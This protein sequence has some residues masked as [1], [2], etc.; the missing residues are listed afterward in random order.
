MTSQSARKDVVL[1]VDD[2]PESLGMIN[3][4]LDAAGLTV[5]VALEGQQALTIASNITPDIILLD[6]LMPNMD[7]FETCR[8]L[9]ANR[10]LGHIPVIFMTGLSDTES[11]V[12]GLEAGGVDYIQKPVNGDELVARMKVHLANARLTL[13]ARTALDSAGQF[14]FATTD[15]GELLWST[16]QAHQLFTVSGADETWLNTELANHIEQLFSAHY[17]KEKGLIIKVGEQPLEVRYIGNTKTNEHLMRLVDLQRPSDT[18]L[19]KNALEL[20]GREAEVLLW[21]AK[22]K[23]NGEIGTILGV[24]PRTVNKHLEQ[25]FRKLG[26]ENRTSAAVKALSYLESNH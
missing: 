24:S 22:G 21:L 14:L 16:P 8:Q 25:V 10:D 6:A 7:G 17:N 13:S 1:V 20:T 15:S 12:K 9:K 2:S 5:L 3:D 11:I 23:S 18:E 4:T 19:L 26:V